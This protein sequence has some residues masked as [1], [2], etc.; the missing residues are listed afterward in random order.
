MVQSG[1]G[2][3]MDMGIHC[4]DILQ[5]ITG[6]KVRRVSAFTGT[7]TFSYDVE[8]S[9]SALLEFGSGAVGYVDS[10]FNVPDNASQGRLEIYGTRASALAHGT[11]SQG[12]GGECLLFFAEDSGYD[13]QQD[14]I[15]RADGAGV[16]LRGPLANLYEK[17][18]ESFSNS[19]LTGAP[20]EA[21]AFE[22]LHAQQVV[23]CA[24]LSAR[25]NRVVEVPESA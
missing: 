16:Y 15:K 25:E 2:A 11:I 5:F 13:A 21:P 6:D 12:G 14:K 24:Y 3:L 7:R 20:L 23:D 17:E 18:I 10:N 22:A 9:A 8:D 4:I 19:I 1:G